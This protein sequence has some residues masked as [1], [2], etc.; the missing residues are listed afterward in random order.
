[1]SS[2]AT[3]Q[4]VQDKLNEV[5]V[6]LINANASGI[7]DELQRAEAATL[8]VSL[9]AKLTAVGPKLHVQAKLCYSRKFTDEAEA[10][11][12]IPDPNQPQL[13]VHT[14]S[15]EEQPQ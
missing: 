2:E 1:M 6:D 10:V 13:I 3:V 15:G 7:A 5:M 4:A 14:K 8:S 12:D 11:A 9:S